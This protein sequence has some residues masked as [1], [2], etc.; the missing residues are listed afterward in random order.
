M[1]YSCPCPTPPITNDYGANQANRAN[2]KACMD[3]C[4]GPK[5]LALA[6]S[7][8]SKPTVVYEVRAP[9]LPEA[10]AKTVAEI[11]SGSEL[12]GIAK[13][14]ITETLSLAK[15]T[16][17][18][19]RWTP[20][21]NLGLDV[22]A[23][24]SGA[25]GFF[26]LQRQAAA[27]GGA[28]GMSLDIGQLLS[29]VGGA[30][31]GLGNLGEIG[32]GLATVGQLATVSGNVYSAFNQPS[33]AAPA[34]TYAAGPVYGAMPTYPPSQGGV[35][36]VSAGGEVIKG[37]AKVAAKIAGPILE[38]MAAYL[39]IK[40][41]S[42][43][44]AISMI[45]QLGKWMSDPAAIGAALGIGTYEL[46]QLIAADASR[47]RRHM[48]PANGRALRRA[49]RRIKSFHRMCSHIDLIKTRRRSYT[50]CGTCRKSP[51]QC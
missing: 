15:E 9:T 45:R 39:G 23:T 11:K 12:G 43:K 50:R 26:T 1:A 41:L 19:A 20:Y 2:F 44:K 38:K 8:T 42:L 10:V 51:C 35:Y 27:A 40:R 21:L 30:F 48:N 18:T 17:Q 4:Y 36:P 33:Y 47:K 31:T 24:L 32:A 6:P 7:Y 49:A 3:Y 5:Q 25:P 37:M 34:P 14:A 29:G 46:A 28:P 16:Q 13:R 22:I